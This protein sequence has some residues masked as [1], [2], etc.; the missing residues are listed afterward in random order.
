MT[1]ST[2]GSRDDRREIVIGRN[3]KVW[4]AAMA[5]AEIAS[6]F[7]IAL[8]HRDVASFEFLTSDRVWVFSYSRVPAEN[9]ALLAVLAT[10][11]VSEIFYVSSA[12]TNVVARTRCYEYPRVKWQA[13][14][15]ALKIGARIL[16]LGIVVNST[17]ELPAGV[18][19]VTLQSRLNEFLLNPEPLRS[20]ARKL[21]FE[22]VAT[23]FSRKW[24]EAVFSMYSW[25]QWQ[26][27]SWPCLL[28]PVDLVL[29]ALGIRWYGYVNL[30]NRLWI[31]TIS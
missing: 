19:I 16:T 29:R 4:K 30:S 10:A 11:G 28:R 26:L 22:L 18:N 1:A 14:E 13:E 31:S 6:G 20:G 7:P 17:A 24:E 8:G 2:L 9:R 5:R 21:L 3:S 15:E 23:P 27:R 25:L 12:T